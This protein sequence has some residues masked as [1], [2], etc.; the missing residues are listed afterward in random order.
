MPGI[1]RSHEVS[2][3]RVVITCTRSEAETGLRTCSTLT[4]AFI[5]FANRPPNR[6]AASVY[7]SPSV[8]IKNFFLA[9]LKAQASSLSDAD[10][11]ERCKEID[12]ARVFQINQMRPDRKI[13]F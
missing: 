11:K 3:L 2:F 8:H 9:T 12:G 4:S 13:F 5:S 6:I 7:S 1:S 10:Q